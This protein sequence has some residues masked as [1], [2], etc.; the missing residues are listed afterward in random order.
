M[1]GWMMANKAFI[2]VAAIINAALGAFLTY[3]GYFA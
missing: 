2:T 1:G 3:K